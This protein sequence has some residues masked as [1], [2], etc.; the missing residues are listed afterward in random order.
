L[1]SAASDNNADILHLNF[2]SG[3]KPGLFNLPAITTVSDAIHPKLAAQLAVNPSG[4]YG[5]ILLDF[6][7]TKLCQLIYRK[8]TTEK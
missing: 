4:H 7:D 1:S 2:T 8:N 5:C 3:Y 6:A